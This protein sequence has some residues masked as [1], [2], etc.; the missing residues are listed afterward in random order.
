[1]IDG[2]SLFAPN[3]RGIYCFADSVALC[4]QLLKAGARIIQLREKHL[5]DNAFGRLAEAMLAAIRRYDDAVLIVND[6]VEVA[7]AVGADGIHI[8]QQ[9]WHY[10][11]VMERISE[12]VIV[13][14][15][16]DTVDQALDA[17]AAGATYLGA[18]SVF[19]TPTKKDAVLI[20]LDG[21]TRIV[22][23][24]SISVVAIGGIRLDNIDQ[25]AAAGAQYS[26][27]IS[28]INDAP[29]IAKRFQAFC[30][31]MDASDPKASGHPPIHQ[32][33]DKGLDI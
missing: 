23:A 6:R 33:F 3:R 17:Q 2:K 1:M 19:P 13:G 18:G 4:E 5:D 32:R 22:E 12:E 29:D 11:D 21:L 10:R 16:V 31:A 9:D 26:A 7:I 15:S 8:G 14:V 24:V 27:I 25:V 28:H 20:G 30:Q